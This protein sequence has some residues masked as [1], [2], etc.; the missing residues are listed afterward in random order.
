MF[1]LITS[2]ESFLPNKVPFLGAGDEDMDA[3]GVPDS[4]YHTD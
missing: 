1:T 3:F 2:A 4:A